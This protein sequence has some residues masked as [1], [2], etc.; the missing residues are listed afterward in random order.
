MSDLAI[1][2]DVD[3]ENPI[4]SDLRLVDG[5]IVL[6]TKREAIRQDLQIR[7]RWFKGEWFLDFRL[8]VP[9]FQDLLGQPVT[10]ELVERVLRRVILTTPGVVAITRF[11]LTRDNAEREATIDFTVSTTEGGES[12]EFTDFVLFP[13]EGVLLEAA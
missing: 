7:L 11:I 4:A 1:V 10:D 9:W 13:D 5:Q 8:G 3:E 12:L 6:V 2:L